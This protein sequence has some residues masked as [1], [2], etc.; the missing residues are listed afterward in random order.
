MAARAGGRG[1]TR[2]LA[3]AAAG[4]DRVVA[5]TPR[6]L[7]R[8]W[9]AAEPVDVGEQVDGARLPWR[10]AAGRLGRPRA[11]GAGTWA[12]PIPGRSAGR[13]RGR[14]AEQGGPILAG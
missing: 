12:D 5:D 6:D 9:Q 10:S 2:L 1:S 8:G 7:G 11:M 13:R 4:C 14:G 3:G